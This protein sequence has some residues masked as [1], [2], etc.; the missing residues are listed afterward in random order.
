MPS[1]RHRFQQCVGHPFL[2]GVA[3]CLAGFAPLATAQPEIYGNPDSGK[4]IL[5]PPDADDWTR[6]F[7]VGAMVGLNISA[8]FRSQGTFNISGNNPGKGIYDDGYVRTDQ[9]GNAGGYTSYWGYDN[10]SQYNAAANTLQMHSASTYS[11]G[12]SGSADGNVFPG[13]EMAYGGN[14]WYWK[15]ARVG[16]ELG[17]GLLP[18]RISDNRPM[19]GSVNQS[20]YSFNTTGIVVPGAPYQGG[21]SGQ[22][23]LISD[24]PVKGD[25][26]T[27]PAIIT[28]TRSLNVTLYTIRLGPS[29][30]WDVTEKVG[31]SFGAGPA[32]G[33]VSGD[34]N[35]NETITS[36]SDGISA[37]NHGQISATDVVYGGY[38]NG[39]VMYHINDFG[40]NADLYLSVQY[41]PL[42]DATIG[43]SHR[44]GQLN[45]SGQVYISAGINWPF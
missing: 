34:F 4:F 31:L 12:G 18:I 30:Y 2:W 44:E 8:N 3:C 21:S 15:H 41:M 11:T 17:F 29:F 10:A 45:L 28:G 16:W 22:G 1:A 43:D 14:L 6:H 40:R 13:F 38:V 35:Y 9:T 33:I 20:A 23:P 27:S 42:S 24:A 19:S 37:H 36:L 32:L 39:T 7:R 25:Q 26:T 5:I